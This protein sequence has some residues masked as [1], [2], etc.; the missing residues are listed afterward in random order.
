M[1]RLVIGLLMILIGVA[2]S[3]TAALNPAFILKV[4]VWLVGWLGGI[5]AAIGAILAGLALQKEVTKGKPSEVLTSYEW[6]PHSQQIENYD[7]EERIERL[8]TKVGSAFIQNIRVRSK[9]RQ[10]TAA[11]FAVVTLFEQA[12]WRENSATDLCIGPK[13]PVKLAE[14]VESDRV[15]LLLSQVKTV[16]CLGLV[17]SAEVDQNDGGGLSMRRAFRLAE[18][19][20]YSS[21]M[22]ERPI[23]IHPVPMGQARTS[24]EAGSK[25][26][27][28]QR[29]AVLLGVSFN[30]DLISENA[31]YDQL[32][33][34]VRI[35]SVDLNDYPSTWRPA[36]PPVIPASQH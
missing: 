24:L 34:L 15:A 31:A 6:R 26:E 19:I 33:L 35:Q 23:D 12:Y 22:T 4:G 20:R 3:V 27:R 1:D 21:V 7:V 11:E 16:L 9:G 36:H 8:D 5:T 28:A 13:R 32:R 17:S 2:A 25:G 30:D 29:T 14:E 10:Q 18:W